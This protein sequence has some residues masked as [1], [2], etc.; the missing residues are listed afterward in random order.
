MRLD[1]ANLPSDPA[2]LRRLVRD[3]A[4]AV[5]RRDGEI[6]RLQSIIKALQRAQYGRRSERLDPNQ[7]ALA[8]EDLE[9]DIGHVEESAPIV[10]EPEP[11]VPPKRRALPGHLPRE[12]V[13]IEPAADLCD[14]C[15]GALHAAGESISEMLDW[16]P[17]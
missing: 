11:G 16:A 5:E 3:M 8:F 4:E 17:A 9:G 1:L 13:R 2:L 7:L 12:E 15:G 10:V 6:E 14:G